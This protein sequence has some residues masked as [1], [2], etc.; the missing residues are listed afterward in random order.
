MLLF[1]WRSSLF[2]ADV[3]SVDEKHKKLYP[4]LLY[5]LKHK[6]ITHAEDSYKDVAT[7]LKDR[8]EMRTKNLNVESMT[9]YCRKRRVTYHWR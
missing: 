5:K 4:I 3:S 9:G 6:T 2:L 7:P 1:L 8:T